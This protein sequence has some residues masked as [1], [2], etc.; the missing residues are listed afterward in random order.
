MAPTF[1]QALETSRVLQERLASAPSEKRATIEH[2]AA[3]VDF[4]TF[5]MFKLA[6][7]EHI[8][9]AMSAA[10]R[11][12]LGKGLQW[13]AGLGIPAVGAAHLIGRDARHQGEK[14]VDHTRN[15]ALLTAL[16]V[17]GMQGIGKALG[18][19]SSPA[20]PPAP[21]AALP[22]QAPESP[23]AYE[24]PLPPQQNWDDYAPEPNEAAL[25]PAPGTGQGRQGILAD[26]VG[27]M[28]GLTLE[29]LQGLTGYLENEGQKMG[30]DARQQ[31]LAAVVLL[32]DVLEQQIAKL[33]GV[34]QADALE[35]LR[36][37]R[38][39]GARLLRELY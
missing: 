35:C 22:M 19:G 7:A 13:G 31:K 38:G 17:G 27:D 20:P 1:T 32:D 14:L 24:T 16:G 25:P 29:D 4:A 23:Q 6:W 2:C 12:P 15:Q 28:E 3:M 8:R 34:E 11:S 33:A 37:N 9:P 10:A 36:L 18:G 26:Q 5:G 21:A 30:S 39:Y